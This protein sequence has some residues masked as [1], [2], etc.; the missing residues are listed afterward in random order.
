M[1]RHIS[2]GGLSAVEEKGDQVGKQA[3]P[4]QRERERKV[5]GEGDI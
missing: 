1:G 4:R 5:T 2:D 3:V